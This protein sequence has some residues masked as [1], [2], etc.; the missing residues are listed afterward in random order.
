M[1]LWVN[2]HYADF[3]GDV[4][5]EN[6]LETFEKGLEQQVGLDGPIL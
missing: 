2:N 6:Y 5:M 4:A 3:E 1:L